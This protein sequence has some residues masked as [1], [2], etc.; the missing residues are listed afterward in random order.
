LFKELHEIVRIFYV[1][2]HSYHDMPIHVSD[3]IEEFIDENDEV[4]LF[5]SIKRA[6]LRDNCPW[7]TRARVINLP[8]PEV[9][10]LSRIVYSL[11]LPLVLPFFYF[12]EKPAFVYERASIS[13]LITIL[14]TKLLDIPYV[15]EV[16]GMV[17][18]ELRMGNQPNWRIRITRFWEAA[19]YRNADLIIAVTEKT[20]ESLVTHYAL[21]PQ[22]VKVVTNGTNIRRFKPVG[23]RRAREYYH[24]PEQKVFYVGYLG[25]LTPWCGADLIA[26]CAPLVLAEFPS[27]R[28]LIGGGQEPFLTSLKKRVESAGLQA[29][30]KF[31]GSIPWAKAAIFIGAL[32]IAVVP[33]IT[34]ADSGASPL[35]L[36]SYLA[37][38]I[39]VV[40]SD[41]G[42][43][44]DVIKRYRVG[45]TF[46]PGDSRG[47]AEAIIDLLHDSTLRDEIRFTARQ[48]VMDH[49]SWRVKVTQMKQMIDEEIKRQ[50]S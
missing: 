6:F 47:L 19:V 30:F 28:F 49:Y 21:S 5:T 34:R 16:N 10:F 41:M 31:F 18:E 9:R 43:T 25:T 45:L 17:V 8:A 3:V 46:I 27:L 39:P 13:A 29:Y 12:L 23:Q 24:L 40:G 15:V 1:Y 4:Y 35:K 7:R 20:K 14:I 42:E 38:G 37:C 44:G 22:K 2:Y 26:E 48:V 11:L 32:D 36:F 50:R 33:T